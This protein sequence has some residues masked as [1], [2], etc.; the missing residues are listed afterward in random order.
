VHHTRG[1]WGKLLM[2]WRLWVALARQCHDAVGANPEWAR[3][4]GLLC[5]R[6]KWLVPLGTPIPNYPARS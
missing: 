6:G 1:R 2:D 5:E 3:S 4:K